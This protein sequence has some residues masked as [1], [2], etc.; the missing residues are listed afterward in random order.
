MDGAGQHPALQA[1]AH[2]HAFI[3]V[4]IPG[5][6]LAG[7][8]ANLRLNR[9][10]PR[11]SAHQEHP[12]QIRGLHPRVLHGLLNRPA[13]CGN[14]MRGQFIKAG[15]G[16][17]GFQMQGA[18]GVLGEERQIDRGFHGGGKLDLGFFGRFCQALHGHGVG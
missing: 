10:N 11:G 18:G 15:T 14:Q 4:D 7:Q 12:A 9:G 16:Q 8:A 17:R 5:G 6:L 3:R 13:G 2:G 1:G